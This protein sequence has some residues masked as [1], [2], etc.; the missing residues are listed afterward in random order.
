[1][2]KEEDVK[3]VAD[4]LIETIQVKVIR[5]LAEKNLI[6]IRKTNSANKNITKKDIDSYIEANFVTLKNTANKSIQETAAKLVK[7]SNC[8]TVLKDLGI[9]SLIL[10][11]PMYPISQFLIKSLKDANDSYICDASLCIVSL[12]LL[13]YPIV[14]YIMKLFSGL[15]ISFKKDN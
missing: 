4:F 7:E 2:S 10:V 12:L 13:S 15:Y 5:D 14:S 6:D 1:M 9:L 11:P 3:R 8:I